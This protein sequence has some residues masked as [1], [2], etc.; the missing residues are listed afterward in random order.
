MI[1]TCSYLQGKYDS[2]SQRKLQ[3]IIT[4][5]PKILMFTMCIVESFQTNQ[6]ESTNSSQH[7]QIWTLPKMEDWAARNNHWPRKVAACRTYRAFGHLRSVVMGGPLGLLWLVNEI[8]LIPISILFHLLY[9]YHPM[10]SP[11][12]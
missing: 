1:H 9:P 4:A 6:S 5:T 7:S 11:M 12:A 2:T 8:T 10:M 3:Q